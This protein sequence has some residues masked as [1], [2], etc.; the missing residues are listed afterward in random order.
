MQ[1]TNG[2]PFVISVA[3]KGMCIT[4]FGLKLLEQ[5]G[6]EHGGYKITAEYFESKR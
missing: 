5:M 3:G 6:V 2:G 4:K 1:Y